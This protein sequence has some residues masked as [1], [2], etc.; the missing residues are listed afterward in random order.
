MEELV[1]IITVCYNSSKTIKDTLESILRQTYTNIE[2]I[3]V[4]GK[5]IDNTVSILERYEPLFKKTDIY[6]TWISEPDKGIYDAMNKGLQK[7]KGD[8]IG[9]L[10]SDDFYESDAVEKVVQ[11]NKNNSFTIIS[12]KK[13]KINSK[14]QILKTFDNKKE[15]AKWI[16]K[17]M[18]INHP[19]TFVHKSV[20]DEVGL[21]DTQYKLSADYDFIYRAFNENASF[22]F[23]DSVLVN[24]RNTGATHQTKNMWITLKEDYLIRKKN[25]VF[26]AEFY[27]LK[28]IC[29]NCLIILRNSILR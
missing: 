10:N 27:L 26:F 16:Y 3:V 8:L 24:M 18:P 19:A 25:K 15:I 5:S 20:Y 28:R 4:D 9:I 14:K 23:I 12:G 7:A 6:F 13:N 22:L 29:F 17:I 2:Y 1:S 11:K 21:F